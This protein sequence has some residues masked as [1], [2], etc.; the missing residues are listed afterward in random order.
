MIL[1][2]TNRLD[3]TADY[4]ILELK[5]RKAEYARFNTEDFPKKVSLNW[6]IKDGVIEGFL[7]LPKRQIK[8]SEIKSGW[9]RRPV[10][11][12]LDN[13]FHDTV[14][15]QFIIEESRTALEGLWKTLPCFWVSKPDNIRVAENKMYQ[16]KIA[17][18]IGFIVW[19]T[20]ITNDIVSARMFYELNKKEI[21]YKPLKRSKLARDN[22]QTFIFTNP[23]LS[24]HFDKI[25][26]IK[27][28]PSILQ[29]YIPKSTEL[30]VT[31]IGKKVFA[32]ELDSQKIPAAIHDWRKA[33]HENLKHTPFD[34][35]ADVQKKCHELLERLGLEFGAIDFILTPN[36]EYVFLEINPNG[37]WAWIQ[38]LCPE[39]PLRETLADL[40]IYRNQ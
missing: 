36:G 21:V 22:K 14:S 29:K 5:K 33:L 27:H 28:A 38:Q 30:R 39:I 13:T 18:D 11:P 25:A 12:N 20:I 16:L 35:P 34:L 32:V 8:F 19:P 9:Y 3:Q 15:A 2:V 40:L 7:R 4:L 1:I 26:N 31:V 37:Q 23:V 24:N 17:S 10:L 6:N